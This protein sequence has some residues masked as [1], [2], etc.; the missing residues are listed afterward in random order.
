ML[1]EHRFGVG[2]KPSSPPAFRV[3]LTSGA[4]SFA[5]GLC[6]LFFLTTRCASE[7]H[8]AK[9]GAINSVCW[10]A[11]KRVHFLCSVFVFLIHA[12]GARYSFVQVLLLGVLQGLV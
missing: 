3:R 8:N 4:C 1:I 10:W 11:A 9:T 2:A 6:L 12:N 7:N 5:V